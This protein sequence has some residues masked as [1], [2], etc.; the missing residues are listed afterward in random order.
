MRY[1]LLQTPKGQ[2]AIRDTKTGKIVER[3]EGDGHVEMQRFLE[4]LRHF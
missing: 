2:Y 1:Q 3:G 4:D